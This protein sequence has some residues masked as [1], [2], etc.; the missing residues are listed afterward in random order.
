MV[1][2]VNNPPINAGSIEVRQG[3]LDAI[4]ALEAN[5]AAQAGVIIGAGTTFIAGSDIKEFSL[6]LAEPHLPQVIAA[7]ENCSKPVVCAIHGAALGG[8]FELALGCDGRIAQEGA[9]VGLHTVTNRTSH[10]IWHR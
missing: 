8:G 4:T 5:S 10:E 6:P 1:I 7:I 9:V 3:L 2:T